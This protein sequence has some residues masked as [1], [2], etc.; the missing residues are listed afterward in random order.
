MILIWDTKKAFVRRLNFHNG[1]EDRIRKV[2]IYTLTIPYKIRIFLLVNNWLCR[3]NSFFLK[4]F[5]GFL[6]DFLRKEIEK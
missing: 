2:Y 6:R 4:N 3:F 5:K 1:R